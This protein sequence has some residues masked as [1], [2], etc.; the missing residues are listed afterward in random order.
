MT[1]RNLPT[2]IR[3][4]AIQR[5]YEH[6]CKRV[7]KISLKAFIKTKLNYYYDE[8]LNRI[9]TFS[10][11]LEGSYFW[12]SINNGNFEFYY[13]KVNYPYGI[14]YHELYDTK[15]HIEYVIPIS[16]NIKNIEL[17]N[18][19]DVYPKVCK[20]YRE[21]DKPIKYICNRVYEPK[22]YSLRSLYYDYFREATELEI[23]LYNTIKNNQ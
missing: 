14:H 15:K 19:T 6:Y 3:Y 18:I 10:E 22:T 12:D 23:L 9:F 1:I 13:D 4:L 21:K 17:A 20:L 8:S 11:T 2:S 5:T 16:L 7:L